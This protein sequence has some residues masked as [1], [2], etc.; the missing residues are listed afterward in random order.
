MT[1]EELKEFEAFRKAQAEKKAK[2]QRK[3]NLAIYNEMIDGELAAAIPQL[4][5]LATDIAT[6]KRTVF[7]NFRSILD[8]KKDVLT[9][10]RDGQRSHTFTNTE[11][12]A[13]LTLGYYTLDNYRDTVNDGIAMIKDFICGLA[14]DDKTK[15]LVDMVLRL[16][17]KDQKGNL[18]AS[19]V[20]QLKKIADDLGDQRFIE[21]VDI[22]MQSYAPIMSKQYL[23]AEVRDNPGAEWKP[24]ALSV[25]DAD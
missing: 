7:D 8:M 5:Q 14:T 2:E 4:Q 16:L 6:V 9:I 25:T 10:T 24:I 20:L 19:R 21:G 22:I 13:R 1:A 15:A 23:R 18:K 11:G 3:Q 17:S 12:T